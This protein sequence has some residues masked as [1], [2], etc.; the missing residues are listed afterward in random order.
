MGCKNEFFVNEYICGFGLGFVDL[1][2]GCGKVCGKVGK[3]WGIAG[4][5]GCGKVRRWI[6]AF[7]IKVWL[8]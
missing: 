4:R 2:L 1:D 7:D 3:W 6:W 5:I 8:F